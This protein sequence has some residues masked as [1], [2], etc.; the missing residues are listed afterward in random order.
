MER[1]GDLKY[2][3]YL[4]EAMQRH[5]GSAAILAD[6]AE[7]QLGTELGGVTVYIAQE[8]CVDLDGRRRKT[9]ARFELEGVSYEGCGSVVQ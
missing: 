3:L 2:E 8:S 5:T 6:G 4:I 7:I 9:V 1:K